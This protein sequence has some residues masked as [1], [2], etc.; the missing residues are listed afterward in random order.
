MSFKIYTPD[1]NQSFL[2]TLKDIFNGFVTGKDLA[3]RFFIRDF[4][5]SFEKSIL[6]T[7]WVFLP[8]VLTAGIWIFVT[9]KK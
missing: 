6:G 8:P 4:K 5:A 3:Y 2:Q 9:L 7:F 1:H